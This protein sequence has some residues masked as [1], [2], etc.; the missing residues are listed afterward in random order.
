M[1][2]FLSVLLSYLVLVSNVESASIHCSNQTDCNELTFTTDDSINANGY[3]SLYSAPSPQ[4]SHSLNR[5]CKGALSCAKSAYISGDDHLWCFGYG[6]CAN[7]QLIEANSSIYAY[8]ANSMMHSTTTL[9]SSVFSFQCRGYQSCAHSEINVD[10]STATPVVEGR[11]ALSFYNS[12]INVFQGEL[13]LELYGYYAGY[14]AVL[15][16]R[17]GTTCNIDCFHNGCGGL[18][19]ICD[20]GATCII[21]NSSNVALLPNTQI[22][23]LDSSTTTEHNEQQCSEQTTDKTFDTNRDH[24]QL[25]DLNYVTDVGPICCRGYQSCA[26][27][28]IYY[29]DAATP[30]VVC[31]ASAACQSTTIQSNSDTTIECSGY[32]SCYD[33][34]MT[35][36]NGIVYCYGFYSCYYATITSISTIICSGS[37]SCSSDNIT[38]N[39]DMT[40]YLYGFQA[41][42]YASITCSSGDQCH[43]ICDGDES[44]KD[45][46]L[47]CDGDC[48][49]QCT[50]DTLCPNGWTATPTSNPTTHPTSNPSSSPTNDPTSSPT[51]NPSSNPTNNPSTSPTNNPSSNPTNNPSTSPTNNPSTSPTNNRPTN[52]PSSNPTNNPSTSPTNNP[53]SNPTNNPS[54]SPTNN[55]ST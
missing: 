25:S 53:S 11:G 30:S 42:W 7:I 21:T 26:E 22:L 47:T 39:G 35:I 28:G 17:D 1:D 5:W 20:T 8:G 40:V 24:Y 45:I 10:D 12:T 31:S 16:C 27:T 46:I 19:L 48:S 44:C 37:W 34:T 41:G 3:K 14:E 9:L 49:V 18:E 52:N 2:C 38:S 51:N 55:P 43:I 36:D 50:E 4:Q 54:T 32:W 23:F 15:H 13:T 29:N 33:S 6:S